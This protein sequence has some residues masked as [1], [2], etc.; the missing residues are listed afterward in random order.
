MISYNLVVRYNILH[1]QTN[2]GNSYQVMDISSYGFYCPF[3]ETSLDLS[4]GQKA[5]PHKEVSLESK[6]HD[7]SYCLN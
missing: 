3:C 5:L 1:F 7:D 2:S 4:L 6:N